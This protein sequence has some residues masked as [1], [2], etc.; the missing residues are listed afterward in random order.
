MSFFRFLKCV[1]CS[2][3]LDS[4][5]SGVKVGTTGLIFK[6]TRGGLSIPAGDVVE[7]CLIT[8]KT[9]QN[10]LKNTNNFFTDQ[11]VKEKLTMQVMR[12][13]EL[14]KLFPF[15]HE[16]MFD[17]EEDNNHIYKLTK[18]IIQSYL[19]IKLHQLA[20][21]RNETNL[22]LIRNKLSRII[23]FNHA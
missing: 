11:N 12:K 20:R 23:I 6:K 7:I 18:T 13:L 8:E 14:S 21:I 15:L 22:K 3:A 5:Y 2:K 4:E 19:K 17:T 1:E 16:H 10:H 9:V